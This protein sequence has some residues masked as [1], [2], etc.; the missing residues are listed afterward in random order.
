MLGPHAIAP[1]P[2]AKPNRPP[3]DGRVLENAPSSGPSTSRPRLHR[4]RRLT[5]RRPRGRTRCYRGR[6]CACTGPDQE[7]STAHTRS[8]DRQRLTATSLTAESTGQT[9]PSRHWRTAASSPERPGRRRCCYRPRGCRRR[10]PSPAPSGRS[11]C[12]CFVKPEVSDP[13]RTSLAHETL[14]S[15]RRASA[16]DE[17]VNPAASGMEPVRRQLARGLAGLL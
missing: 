16:G 17:V 1:S 6:S 3:R 4:H 15:S 14:V 13:F 7:S 2:S 10:S 12:R 5:R 9:P 8:L 11:G